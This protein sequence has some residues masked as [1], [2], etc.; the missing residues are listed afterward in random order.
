MKGA[1][2]IKERE[3]G[4][5]SEFGKAVM[6]CKGYFKKDDQFDYENYEEMT[7]EEVVMEYQRTGDDSC[8]AYLFKRLAVLIE[9]QANLFFIE[10]DD[11]VSF[12]F[13]VL[14]ETSLSFV[15]EYVKEGSVKP[16]K[17]INYFMKSYKNRILKEIQARNCDKR[18]ANN[19][20]KY[21]F[22]D[23]RFS[24][25]RPDPTDDEGDLNSRLDRLLPDCK[26]YW[27]DLNFI[28][29]YESIRN[30]SRFLPSEIDYCILAMCYDDIKDS[31][32]AELLDFSRAGIKAIKK[33]LKKKLEVLA[34][35]AS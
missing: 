26:L 32:I 8:I 27:D 24:E 17:F 30:D 1:I 15:S 29:I 16:A 2:G 33:R 12:A 7:I 5:Y 10:D 3:M 13:E 35:K 34:L 14:F 28:D 11:K 19:N 4:N 22:E 23:S 6:V 18:T 31:E 20:C 9:R 21:Y 25:G